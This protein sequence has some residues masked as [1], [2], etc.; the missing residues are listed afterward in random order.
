MQHLNLSGI[1]M[2]FW[3]GM[4]NLSMWVNFFINK[5]LVD[6][7]RES[8]LKFLLYICVLQYLQVLAA[9]FRNDQDVNTSLN[10]WQ[11]SQYWWPKSSSERY[12]NMIIHSS[13]GKVSIIMMV[14]GNKRKINHIIFN[15]FKYIYLCITFHV[16]QCTWHSKL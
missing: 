13:S 8:L 1:C 15:I 11:I 3:I 10:L 2:L 9:V 5:D 16:N 6:I 4:M 12:E 7:Y 14:S